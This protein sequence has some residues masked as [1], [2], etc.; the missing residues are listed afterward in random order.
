MKLLEFGEAGLNRVEYEKGFLDY[1]VRCAF[2]GVQLV[3]QSVQK[4]CLI[5]YDFNS[6]FE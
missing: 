2:E 5:S 1:W 3:E 6:L 4:R